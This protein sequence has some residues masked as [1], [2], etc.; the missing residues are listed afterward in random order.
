MKKHQKNVHGDKKLPDH[1]QISNNVPMEA[2]S[3]SRDLFVI[4]QNE[5]ACNLESNGKTDETTA[6]QE[7]H[8]VSVSEPRQPYDSST[9]CNLQSDDTIH[10][11]PLQAISSD[12]TNNQFSY[13]NDLGHHTDTILSYG[14]QNI[15]IN[16]SVM[17]Q[18]MNEDVTV[19]RTRFLHHEHP[20]L[21]SIMSA[22]EISTTSFTQLKS[23]DII[24]TDNSALQIMVPDKDVRHKEIISL[25]HHQDIRHT[26]ITSL[27][28]SIESSA[29]NTGDVTLRDLM[30]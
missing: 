7:Y 17:G 28:T 26:H 4:Q 16:K 1:D 2:N 19:P 3:Q 20:L 9:E 27:N 30:Q 22:P 11:Q 25:E 13:T 21:T 8:T 15:N 18:L 14:P 29:N 10:G 5:V 12:A 6:V 24:D 23:A